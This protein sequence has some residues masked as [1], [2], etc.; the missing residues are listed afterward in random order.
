MHP[1]TWGRDVLTMVYQATAGMEVETK[2]L[3]PR[4]AVF[5]IIG[6]PAYWQ[7]LFTCITD[8]EILTD[9]SAG[10]GAQLEWEVT[11]AGISVDVREEITVHEPPTQFRWASVEGSDWE[12]EGAVSF[13]R[14]GSERTLVRTY[15]DYDFPRVVD[16]RVGRALFKRR[17]Q[18]EIERSFACVEPMLAEHEIGQ[19]GC[20]DGEHD[21]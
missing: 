3:A 1:I 2:I 9:Y 10:E 11:V 14:L 20:E 21:E 8:G 15:M 17:F 5:E 16:N 4:R 19:D 18:S 12:H 7:E 13:D 6:D